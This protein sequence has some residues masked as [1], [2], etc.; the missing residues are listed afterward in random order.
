MA[1]L[2]NAFMTGIATKVPMKP[3]NTKATAE[4]LG[5]IPFGSS[6]ISDRI[7]LE[8]RDKRLIPVV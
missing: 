4:L 7:C 6:P 5:V 8:Y 1:F 2:L 3:Q